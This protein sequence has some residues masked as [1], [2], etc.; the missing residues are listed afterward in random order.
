MQQTEQYKNTASGAIINP[1]SKDDNKFSKGFNSKPQMDALAPEDFDIVADRETGQV[2]ILHDKA[3]L[4]EGLIASA[5][6]D[7][8]DRSIR[9]VTHDGSIQYLGAKVHKPLIQHL[10]KAKEIAA[11]LTDND[12]NIKNM[13]VVPLK[14][15]N[16]DKNA[17]I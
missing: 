17:K 10:E 4:N 7:Q 11:I 16:T 5:E 3:F 2:W 15:K 1:M 6:Y 12:G 14:Q 9:F 13:F 8:G